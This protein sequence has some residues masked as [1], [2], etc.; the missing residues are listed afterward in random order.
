MNNISFFRI[1]SHVDSV[2]VYVLSEMIAQ[3]VTSVI[4]TAVVKVD[5]HDVFRDTA[6]LVD[7]KNVATLEW[8]VSYRML[9]P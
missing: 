3:V 7:V 2:F 8:R 5:Q 1:V 6:S 4:V 9:P